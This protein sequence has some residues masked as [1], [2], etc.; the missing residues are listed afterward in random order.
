MVRQ[1]ELAV[2]RTEMEVF[3]R[4]APHRRAYFTNL[5]TPDYHLTQAK[6]QHEQMVNLVPCPF[7]SAPSSLRTV[8][9]SAWLVSR[10]Q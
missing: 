4:A 9:R 1:Q 8:L 7:N 3:L 6:A 10:V 5:R 2:I